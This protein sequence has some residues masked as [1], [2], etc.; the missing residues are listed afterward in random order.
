MIYAY[1]AT[2]YS[3]T[4][5]S[6]ERAVEYLK[7]VT[8][9]D[10]AFHDDGSD[11]PFYFDAEEREQAESVN[12]AGDLET[13]RQVARRGNFSL[14]EN[15]TAP[16]N[17]ENMPM[18]TESANADIANVSGE[19]G[20]N[21]S[22][23]TPGSE[24]FESGIDYN[25]PVTVEYARTL[26]KATRVKVDTV[27]RLLGKRVRFAESVGGG[28]ANG[29]ITG[30]EIVLSRAEL[31][32]AQEDGGLVW[33]IL[34][35]EL[36][37][38]VQQDA[39]DAYTLF[40]NAVVKEATVRKHARNI[41]EYYKLRGLSITADAALD[42]AVA[43][44]GGQL[45]RDTDTAERFIERNRQ[46]KSLLQKI[47]DT[48]VKLVRKLTG[49]EKRQVQ[50]VRGLFDAAL[51]EAAKA[52]RNGETAAQKDGGVTRLSIDY[53]SDNAPFVIVEDD[54][55]L[56]VP[57][58]EWVRTVKDNLRQKFPNGVQVGSNIIK[59]NRQSRGEMTFSHY[60]RRLFKTDPAL[61]ADK[62]RATGEKVRQTTQEA[63]E[64]LEGVQG[65]IGS[66]RD[67]LQSV[68]G[69]GADTH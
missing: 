57:A 59:I 27:S 42:E 50:T 12:L 58:S 18:S 61:F 33:K 43:D 9:V 13:K 40:R 31:E 62:L 30:N 63:G 2:L 68:T 66:A 56:G 15:G 22:V 55:L 36:T 46:D 39:G 64:M 20:I 19:K 5:D 29:E 47:R 25:D 69:T 51:D 11:L 67:M 45:M 7:A 6:R 38:G 52:V 35:H 26:E 1:N 65:L 44:Y 41:L 3:E 54:I 23:A 49:A 34:G 4:F 14:D 48:L 28:I 32:R 8:E 53:D 17:S 10:P 60:M 24:A 16:K 21:E 37:H